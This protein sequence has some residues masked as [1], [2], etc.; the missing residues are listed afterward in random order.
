MELQRYVALF[1]DQFVCSFFLIFLFEISSEK[2]GYSGFFWWQNKKHWDLTFI[3]T[4][5]QF[6]ASLYINIFLMAKP[7]GWGIACMS[8]TLIWL[9]SCQ[10]SHEESQPSLDFALKRLN[11]HLGLSLSQH[12]QTRIAHT[13]RETYDVSLRLTSKKR[14][15]FCPS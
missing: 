7:G 15:F 1:S 11:L 6:I 8:H 4:M 2:A 9:G 13:F 3:A 5:F 10:S 12:G 14:I